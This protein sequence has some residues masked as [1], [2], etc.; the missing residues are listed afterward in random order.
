MDVLRRLMPITYTWKSNG[1]RDLGFGAEQMA[2]IEP[3]LTF[4]NEKGEIEGVNYGQIST[5]VVNSIKEQQSQIELQQ[6][7]LQAQQ[8]QI[9]QQQRQIDALKRI[10][11][12]RRA[13]R[14]VQ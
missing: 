12:S 1:R 3:L 9:E 13:N 6:Q 5:V 10:V 8:T 2:E 4:N 14:R 7:Q 11:S